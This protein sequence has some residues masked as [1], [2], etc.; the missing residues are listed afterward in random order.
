MNLGNGIAFLIS[1][2]L[3]LYVLIF[4][5]FSLPTLNLRHSKQ[6]NKALKMTQYQ[7]QSSD[8]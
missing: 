4:D 5:S 2:I 3:V 1:A 6:Q 8:P 7:I